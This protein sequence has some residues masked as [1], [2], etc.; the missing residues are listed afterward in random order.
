MGLVR[1]RQN[2]RSHFTVISFLY[3]LGALPR[4]ASAVCIFT[5]A[6]GF[7]TSNPRDKVFGLLGVLKRLTASDKTLVP[8]DYN[9]SKEQVFRDATCAILRK[10][11]WLG[12]LSLISS[13]STKR[14]P[15]LPSWVL[16]LDEWTVSCIGYKRDFSAP[17]PQLSC[18]EHPAPDL[19][20]H[21]NILGVHGVRIARI[22][23]RSEPLEDV[24][25]FVFDF[26]EG[27]KLFLGQPRIYRYTNEPLI[28]V[29]WRTLIVNRTLDIPMEQWRHSFKSW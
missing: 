2:P 3:W 9:H 23:G 15:G 16:D 4:P 6:V 25:A 5:M 11:N 26:E 12:Y 7:K 28:K 21:D 13:D 17:G 20:F 22:D 18:V 1:N 19:T 14:S 10:T 29:F 24:K 8:V 27:A